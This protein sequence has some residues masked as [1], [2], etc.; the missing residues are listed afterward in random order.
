MT[1]RV[2]RVAHELTTGLR[3][4]GHTSH[5]TDCSLWTRS[6]CTGESIGSVWSGPYLPTGSHSQASCPVFVV[7][8]HASRAST[9]STCLARRKCRDRADLLG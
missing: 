2:R 8:Q 6:C 7:A 5:A 4:P 9:F 3:G 1:I